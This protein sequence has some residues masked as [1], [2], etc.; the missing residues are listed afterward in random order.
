MKKLVFSLCILIL[1]LVGCSGGA[2]EDEATKVDAISIAVESKY[3]DWVTPH[4]EKYTADTGI[5]VNV[6]EVDS[7]YSVVGSLAQTI[8]AGQAPDLVPMSYDNFASTV[9]A[10]LISPVDSSDF[11]KQYG[12]KAADTVMYKGESYLYPL[13]M[14]SLI[15]YYQKSKVSEDEV[16]S[17]DAADIQTII[18]FNNKYGFVYAILE[19]Y[20]YIPL[21]GEQVFDNGENP[22]SINITNETWLTKGAKIQEL[23]KDYP[24]TLKDVTQSSVFAQNMF[25]NKEVGAILDG[26]WSYSLYSEKY[27][28]DLGV[29]S[30]KNLTPFTGLIGY[31]VT[32][33]GDEAKM[34]AANAF[35]VYLTQECMDDFYAQSNF[36]PVSTSARESLDKNDTY[37][38]SQ[39][40]GFENSIPMVKS[41]I[42]GEM[43]AP[44]QNAMVNISNGADVETEFNKAADEIIAAAKSKYEVDIEKK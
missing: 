38:Q 7:W 37:I 39:I 2:K 35:S 24:T 10:Q 26:P 22:T 32:N 40:D 13:Q 18:D 42:G 34:A 43:W 20:Q 3:I 41:P 6:E 21:I 12:Q 25:A 44:L 27:G 23:I 17:M 36:I 31:A 15:L 30:M 28:D 4:A 14:E 9:D 16:L 1:G 8:P 19:G 11:V 5:T 29:A 33:S